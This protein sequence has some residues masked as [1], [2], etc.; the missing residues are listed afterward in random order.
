MPYNTR[1]SC[2]QMS[3]SS[4]PSPSTPNSW[5]PKYRGTA[6]SHSCNS[7]LRHF[8]DFSC[9]YDLAYYPPCMPIADT[10]LRDVCSLH[11]CFKPLAILRARLYTL[12]T[13]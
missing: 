9:S 8:C 3:P 12:S 2:K 4:A 10:S 11:R 6:I 1:L 13:L 7:W 5:P